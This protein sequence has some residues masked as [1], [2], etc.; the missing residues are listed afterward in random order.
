MSD[1]PVAMMRENFPHLAPEALD[2]MERSV[3]QLQAE[4]VPLNSYLPVIDTTDDLE[5]PTKEAILDR[6]MALMVVALR[7]EGLEPEF[8]DP[9]RE[10]LGVDAFLTPEEASYLANPDASVHDNAQFGWRYASAHVLFWSLGFVDELGRPDAPRDPGPMVRMLRDEP[11]EEILAKAKLRSESE[12]LD[13][14][15]LIYRY[16]WALVDARINGREPPAGLDP[17]VAL[18]WHWALNWL[19]DHAEIGWDDT[20]LDT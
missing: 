6:A 19:I 12:I 20:R 1:D 5:L 3:R 11:R 16:R 17:S 10:K 13:A 2:R 14:A 18:E 9:F 4:G 8:L 15:D 7:G